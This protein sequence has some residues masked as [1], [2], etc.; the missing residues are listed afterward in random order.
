MKTVVLAAGAGN[1]LRPL[2]HNTPKCLIRVNGKPILE[3]ALEHLSRNGIGTAV[4]VIG[5]LGEKVREYL[6]NQFCGMR[7]IYVENKIFNV[8]NNI[9][10]LWLAKEHLNDDILLLE[11]DIFFEAEVIDRTCRHN[12]PDIIVVDVYQSFME[13]TG[14]TVD[15]DI[16][17]GVILKENKSQN[18]RCNP[19]L[20]TVNIYKFS[21]QFMETY[22]IPSLEEVIAEGYHSMFYEFAISRIVKSRAVQLMALPITGLKWFEIDTPEDLQQAE[23]LFAEQ[24]LG[25]DRRGITGPGEPVHG[26]CRL[27]EGY[28]GQTDHAI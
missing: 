14:V 28:D 24:E 18:T 7:L 16:V 27:S 13:G 5:H 17:T 2:T 12:Y 15:N 20:K 19:G 10:S 25:I 21:K 23:R 9:Y 6:G 22:L 3:N 1:R 11:D 4:I 8:T 26:S